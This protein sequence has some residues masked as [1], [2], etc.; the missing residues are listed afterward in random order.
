MML[1]CLICLLVFYPFWNKCQFYNHDVY[2]L[3]V[4]YPCLHFQAY[5]EHCL[6]RSIYSSHICLLLD[7]RTYQALSTSGPLHM[8]MLTNAGIYKGPVFLFDLDISTQSHLFRKAFS[9]SL[10]WATLQ[11]ALRHISSLEYVSSDF[12]ITLFIYLFSCVLF[13]FSDTCRQNLVWIG[14]HIF[15]S[16]WLLGKA[17]EWKEKRKKDSIK[18]A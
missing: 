9:Y 7:S 10:K 4:I 1:T 18:G 12:M 16:A 14:H 5:L 13:L 17:R 6:F 11:G 8:F 3:S 2:G 15:H